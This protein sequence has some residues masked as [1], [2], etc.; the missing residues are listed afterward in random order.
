M[1]NVKKLHVSFLCLLQAS[2]RLLSNKNA[3]STML[4]DIPPCIRTR[5]SQLSLTLDI[6]TLLLDIICPK[7]RP[8]C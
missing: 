2:S 3:L 7:L 1:F 5:I 4:N 8:V 6:L